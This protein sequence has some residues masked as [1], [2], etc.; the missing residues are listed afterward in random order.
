MYSDYEYPLQFALWCLLLTG[1][2]HLFVGVSG[3]LWAPRGSY[4]T[5]LLVLFVLSGLLALAIQV[6]V[7]FTFDGK[8]RM[9]YGLTAALMVVFLLA[10]AD[11]HVFGVLESVSPV[12]LTY[13]GYHG[14]G[15]YTTVAHA[16]IS[17]PAA[18][19]SK[20]A[21]AIAALVFGSYAV[22]DRS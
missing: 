12:Q 13:R 10:Y 3:L 7:L 17:D 1:L 5:A 9:L 19:V 16:I 14:D 22:L 6:K 15:R 21:E 8:T 18:L 2:W 11:L 4:T 20:A